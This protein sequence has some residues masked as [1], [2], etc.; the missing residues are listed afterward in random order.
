MKNQHA[1]LAGHCMLFL[2]FVQSG[3]HLIG[4]I[5]PVGSGSYTTTFPGVD[6]AN[7]NSYPSGSPV[8]S[9]VAATKPVPTNDWWSAKIKNDHVNNLFNYPLAL[10]TVNSG[11]VVSYIIAP[12][13]ANGSSQPMD[14]ILPIIVGVTGLDA[15]KATVSDFSDWTVTMNWANST[16]SY[17]ATAGIAMPFLYFTKDTSDVAQITVNEGTVTIDNEMLI[18]ENA[19]NGSDFSVYAPT[20]STWIKN[21][22]IYTST[23]NN[24]NYWSMAFI[25]P[26]ASSITTVANE[27]KKYA[28]VFPKDTKVSWNYNASTSVVRTTFTVATDIK[29]GSDTTILM[30]LLPHQWGHLAGDSPVPGGYSYPSI[31]GEI[32]TLD[33]NEFYV[34]NTFHGILP[35]LPYLDNYS[36]GFNPASLNEKIQLLENESLSTWT[37]SYNEGQAM[38]CLI[39][40]ARIADL[41]GDTIARNKILAT[42]KERLENWLKAEPGEV[43]FLFYY[44]ST[45]STMIGYP[46]GYGQDSNIN[47]HHFHWGY[48]IHAAAFVEQFD[49][50][51]ANQ[52]GGMINLL[53]R[54]AAS[55][56]RNDTMFPFLRNFSPYAGHSWADGFASFPLGNDEESTSESM[57]FNSSLIHWGTIT[58]NQEIRD[59][60]IYLYTT[61]QTAIEEYWFD[62]HNR[63][64]KPEYNYSIV[65]RIWGNGYDNQTFWTSDIAAAYGIEMYP[66]HGG[67]LY[68]GHHLDYVQKLWNE[69]KINTGILTNQADAN[70]WH[71]VIWEYL[72]F[73]DPQKAI[74]LYNSYPNRTLKFGISDAQTYYWLHSM[75]ALGNVDDS[76]TADCPVA[77]AFYKNGTITYVAQNYSNSPITVHFSDGY[78]LQVPANKLV[79]S[80]D[81]SLN[82][83][84]TTSLPQAYANGSVELNVTVS[85]GTATK[86]EFYDGATFLGSITDLPYNFNAA[87]LIAGKHSFYARVYEGTSFNVT[88]IASVIVGRQLPYSGTAI[89]IPGTIQA[90]LYDRFEGG[91]GQGITYYDMTIDNQGGFRPTEYVDAA[92]DATEGATVGWIDP[93]EWLEY[94]VNV[95]NSGLYSFTFRYA[96]DNDAGGGPFYLELDDKV[97]SDSIFVSST[98]AWD[99]WASKTVNNVPLWKGDHILRVSFSGGEFNLGK[100]TF[101][102]SAPLS[103]DQPYADAGPNIMVI[104]PVDSA[105]LDGTKSTDPG[106]EPLHYSWSQIYGPSKIVFSNDSIST[107]EITSLAEG[108]YLIKLTVSNGLYSDFDELYVIVSKNGILAPTVFI[109]SPQDSA[110]YITGKQATIEAEASDLDGSVQ[111]VDFYAGANKIGSGTSE[112]YEISW[113]SDV[114]YYT[115]TAVATDNEGNSDTSQA[116][117]IRFTEAPPCDG[118]A[119]NGD[120]SYVFSDDAQNPTLT[121]I[122]SINGV[123]NPTCILYYNTNTNPPFPGYNVT[124]NTP[125]RITASEGTTVYF[126]YTYS[127][128]GE[129]ERNTS[130]HVNSYVTGSCSSSPVITFVDENKDQT[131]ILCYP[132]PVTSVLTILL[133]DLEN[134]IEVY[135][136]GGI[137]MNKL[138]LRSTI[139]Q[140][141]MST[142][143]SGIYFIEIVNKIDAVNFKVIKR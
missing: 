135:D 50:G 13:G 25:P 40:T 90:G 62:I 86:I 114:G 34:E 142:F 115:I 8:V 96:S 103:Y 120:Y 123:G 81:I 49:P 132:N 17:N 85:G 88:N 58:G 91:N 73:I 53:I 113:T 99:T 121:F 137:L 5:V 93:G 141:D 46:A 134:T 119:Y 60:G 1:G 59:L 3:T 38:N 94:S 23:L 78:Y 36:T 122:P 138:K 80:R 42:I 76:L 29:E 130:A 33:G 109:T 14:D 20:G 64:F 95:L 69:I 22:N 16:H 72:A 68:L 54:D 43:A 87:L 97:I 77:A 19:R 63:T 10:R 57:Q 12:S 24:R 32:K 65:S 35:T 28:Y 15:S 45:W 67:S 105:A 74:E 83:I 11:L 131:N 26:S 101:T 102:Y 84:L 39:Q 106:S 98:G 117:T 140:Y 124:P 127:Y 48:F 51:W 133:P 108:I 116:I 104:L 4:Q 112:P 111:K 71:D 55:T 52:W 118:S 21:G 66:I 70:L 44:D 37:D 143:S 6:A 61:E 125:Y 47:D 18:I 92:M 139:F 9:G 110:E 107:P 129:G 7:R 100:M 31:R 79:T 30:G 41:T 27:Y 75:N 128:P 126:Y 82:G 89:S 2:L 56:D 136:I